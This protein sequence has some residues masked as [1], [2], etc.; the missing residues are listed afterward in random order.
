MDEGR[1]TGRP[2][3]STDILAGRVIEPVFTVT[4]ESGT[5]SF[6]NVTDAWIY[7]GSKL[8]H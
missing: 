4:D 8:E 6:D 2:S 7:I 1:E 3:V 5:V